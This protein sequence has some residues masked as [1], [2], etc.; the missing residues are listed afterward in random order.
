MQT[1]GSHEGQRECEAYSHAGGPGFESL[2]AHHSNLS[3]SV[4]CGFGDQ[5]EIFL[6]Q[7]KKLAVRL[8]SLS[9]SFRAL[10]AR[11]ISNSLFEIARQVLG[12]RRVCWPIYNRNES[13]QINQVHQ[14]LFLCA[15]FLGLLFEPRFLIRDRVCKLRTSHTEYREVSWSVICTTRIQP[16]VDELS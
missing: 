5:S 9:I 1:Q 6:A 12:A 11:M 10:I 16:R 4:V 15:S 2:R 14:L 13:F 8:G 3:E 7:G